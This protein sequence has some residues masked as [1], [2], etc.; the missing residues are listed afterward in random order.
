MKEKLLAF[1]QT[2]ANETSLY[3]IKLNKKNIN[4]I[5]I[6]LEYS[7]HDNGW[8]KQIQGETAAKLHDN[9]NGVTVHLHDGS[10][11][12][13]LTYSD[14]LELNVLLEYYHKHFNEDQ[15]IKFYKAYEP[16]KE[17]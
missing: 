12:I 5:K 14:I 4:N 8:T 10:K 16:R 3:N 7:E 6:K 2:A 9:G 13:E 1:V 15:T 17:I 11:N